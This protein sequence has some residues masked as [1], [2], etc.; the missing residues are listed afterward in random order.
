MGPGDHRADEPHAR[1]G[2]RR[3][4]GDRG[5]PV[6]GQQSADFE[7]TEFEPGRRFA[8]TNTSGPFALDRTFSFEAS[9][10]GTK[11][12]FDFD[13]TPRI[14]PVRMLFPLVNKTIASQVR[15][16][17]GNLEKLLSKPS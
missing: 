6:H 10:R 3:H 16:N 12:S 4:Q 2:G 14:L 8:F 1:T 9:D 5:A 11:L 13:M 15:S 17:I 7:V